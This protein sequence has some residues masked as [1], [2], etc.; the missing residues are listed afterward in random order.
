M[1]RTYPFV[2]DCRPKVARRAWPTKPRD[3][4][5]YRLKRAQGKTVDVTSSADRRMAGVRLGSKAEVKVIHFYVRFT[6]ESGHQRTT[7]EFPLLRSTFSTL[8]ICLH[9]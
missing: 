5:S 3:R 6:P 2:N 4:A 9:L 8:S 1:T 7:L